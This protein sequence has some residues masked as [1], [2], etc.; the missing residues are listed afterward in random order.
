MDKLCNWELLGGVQKLRSLRGAGTQCLDKPDLVSH[1]DDVD[2]GLFPSVWDPV[3]NQSQQLAGP[4]ELEPKLI[5]GRVLRGR[6]SAPEKAESS[7]WT[8]RRDSRYIQSAARNCPGGVT[9]IYERRAGGQAIIKLFPSSLGDRAGWQGGGCACK[10]TWW[11]RSLKLGLVR[12]A[13]GP[14]RTGPRTNGGFGKGN[15]LDDLSRYLQ[16]VVR[17][18]TGLLGGVLYRWWLVML[19]LLLG[20]CD[21][22]HH[23]QGHRQHSQQEPL[24]PCQQSRAHLRFLPSENFQSMTG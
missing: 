24:P 8:A 21:F 7:T 10:W 2:T 6:R 17:I 14:G 4:D 19:L 13:L 3:E 9:A 15:D 11:I 20:W 1:E 18:E 23:H 5:P 22:G 12:L 16:N